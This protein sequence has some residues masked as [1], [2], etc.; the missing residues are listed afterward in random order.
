M[1]R[2]SAMCH[3]GIYRRLLM[4]VLAPML[5]LGGVAV[6]AAGN[7]ANVAKQGVSVVGNQVFIDGV[8]VEPG[9]ERYTSPTT[10]DVYR[11][12]RREGSVAVVLEQSG[13]KQGGTTRIESYASG[14]SAT[15]NA[16]QVVITTGQ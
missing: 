16:G 3:S 8:E 7:V 9:V 10:G 1:F 4:G 6:Y 12:Q 14:R 2:K 13:G 15:V 5:T 11:I